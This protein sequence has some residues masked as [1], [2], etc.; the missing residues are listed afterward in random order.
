MFDHNEKKINYKVINIITGKHFIFDDD[1]L[2]PDDTNN[3]IINKII[4]Y[5]YPDSIISINEIYAYSGD[6]SICFEYDNIGIMNNIINNNKLSD[7]IIDSDF[8]NELGLQKVVK[9]NNNMN[10]LFEQNH[11]VDNTVYYFSLR[12]LF[13][14]K[15]IDLMKN[16]DILEFNSKIDMDFK[17]FFNGLIRKYF[18]KISENNIKNYPKYNKSCEKDYIRIKNL[19]QNNY[20]IFKLI[21]SKINDKKNLLDE[22]KKTFKLMK[23][24]TK[25]NSDNT[26]NITKLFSDFP[27][28]NKYFLSKLILEDYEDT[29]FKLY[30]KSLK[31][32][33]SSDDKLVTK[34]LCKLFLKDYKEYIP[35]NIGFVPSFVKYENI[36]FLKIHTEIK[37]GNIFFSFILHLDGNVDLIINNYN[38]ITIDEED[39]KQIVDE[40]NIII[41]RINNNRIYSLKTIP[42]LI[43]NDNLTLEYFN[44]DLIYDLENFIDDKGRYIYKKTNIMK[45]INNFY[46]HFRLLKE[47]MDLEDNNSIHVHYKRVSE[48]ENMDVFDSIISTMKHP[49]FDYSNDQIIDIIHENYGISMEAARSVFISWDEKNTLKEEQGKKIYR[50]ASKE[51]GSQIIIDKHL[52][53]SLKIQIMNISSFQELNR[54]IKFIRFMFNQYQNHISGNLD[55][56][57]NDLF[58]DVNKVTEKI[59]K[60][61]NKIVEPSKIKPKEIVEDS[62]SSEEE[63]VEYSDEEIVEE[64]EVEVVKKSKQNDKSSSGDE[65][66]TEESSGSEITTEESSGGGSSE[67]EII[68]ISNY[69]TKKLES[70]DS[71]LFKGRA[72]LCQANANKQAVALS[73]DEL[74]RIDKNDILNFLNVS[75]AEK[76]KLTKLSLPELI[77]QT[78][79]PKSVVQS[80]S[81][82]ISQPKLNDPSIKVNYICPKYWNI[83]SDLPIHP[84]DIHKYVDDI[85]PHGEKKGKTDKYVFSRT[86]SQWNHLQDDIF[87]KEI[88]DLLIKNEIEVDKKILTDNWNNIHKYINSLNLNKKILDSIDKI[89]QNIV[90]LIEPRWMASKNNIG[91]SKYPCCYKG[92]PKKPPKVE[93]IVI[94]NTSIQDIKISKLSPC[95]PGR[96]CHVHPKLQKLFNHTDD[97]TDSNLGGFIIRGVLQDNY[98]LIHSL[99]FLD[100]NYSIKTLPKNV[101]LNRIKFAYTKLGYTKQKIEQELSNKNNDFLKQYLINNPFDYIHNILVKY[102]EQNPYYIITKI[103][104]GNIVQLF[105]SDKFIEKDIKYFIITIRRD[106]IHEKFK[107]LCLDKDIIDINTYFKDFKYSKNIVEDF[108][109]KTLIYK[110]SHIIIIIYNIIISHNN[111]IDYLYSLEKKDYKYILPLINEMYPKNIFIFENKNESI[112]LKLQ[113]FKYESKNNCNFIYK[114]GDIY[115]PIVYFNKNL[116]TP[117]SSINDSS[118]KD[119]NVNKYI[120]LIIDGINEQIEQLYDQNQSQLNILN[121][122]DI[123][124]NDI[125]DHHKKFSFL[126]DSYCKISHIIDNTTSNIYPISPTSIKGDHFLIYNFPTKLPELKNISYINY[127]KKGIIVNKDNFI[128]EVIFNNNTYIPI[129]P[130]KYDRRNRYPI[131]GQISINNINNYLQT[132]IPCSDISNKFNNDYNYMKYFTRLVIQ[133]IIYYIKNDKIN[134]DYYTYDNGIYEKNNI[135]NFKILSHN[136]NGSL[137][138]FVVKNNDFF[139]INESNNFTGKVKNISNGDIKNTYKLSIEINKENIINIIVNN[140]IILNYDKQ[141]ELSKI[142]N[143]IIDTNDIFQIKNDQEYI[144]YVDKLLKDINIYTDKTFSDK[145][146]YDNKSNKLIINS[147]YNKYLSVIKEKVIWNLV[148]LLIINKNID[149][150]NNILQNNID[151]GDLSKSEKEGEIFFTYTEFIRKDKYTREYIKLNEIFKFKSS[152]IR[153]INF[154]DFNNDVPFNVDKYEPLEPELIIIPNIIKK[155]FGNETTIITYLDKFNMNFI[156]IER[157]LKSC[158]ENL[159]EDYNTIKYL[160][161]NQDNLKIGM[162]VSFTYNK[163]EYNG[164]IDSFK[165]NKAVIFVPKFKKKLD[166]SFSKLMYNDNFTISIED[167]QK[168][169]QHELFIKYNI[170]F[171]LITNSEDN[172]NLRQNIQLIYNNPNINTKFILLYHLYNKKYDSYNLTNIMINNTTNFLTLEELYNN[173]KI[174]Q[175]IITDYPDIKFS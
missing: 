155:L 131:I 4:N 141:V 163:K 60:I 144:L 153:E 7:L 99:I 170:G 46:T 20:D 67:S 40:S 3:M 123:V 76:K 24:S 120:K 87:K 114:N 23:L 66:S 105:K 116:S 69:F 173:D 117:N 57:Y 107:D 8:V 19:V 80:Y 96:F 92:N 55:K 89:Y 127:S 25:F 28:T 122:D 160:I 93:N 91:D 118:N 166:I 109:N 90:N 31:L 59:S 124:D 149:S 17:I 42:E 58:L 22:D 139:N 85:I 9:L 108:I 142:L 14:T 111:Y 154:Y 1:Q 143:D 5:C 110:N 98:S 62:E 11:I 77:K 119:L 26:I 32:E 33:L 86:G 10:K 97:I 125:A 100:S 34:N 147:K 138:N 72:R 106:D 2:Y 158:N 162:D 130:I 68:N 115:E 88:Y 47:R 36:F 128:I 150:V 75:S 37:S 73:D 159:S 29:Y 148:E 171:L 35:L 134:N 13:Q 81:H 164:V 45:F 112:N 152:F 49:R 95:N 21:D 48:Y 53:K 44:I 121:Y 140:N 61:E 175:I 64:P 63:V 172:T 137:K 6:K 84:R 145:C 16:P 50:F 161:Y 65:I 70:H 38:N 169:T 30:K 135:Y 79:V 18:P 103:G 27:L 104:D 156:A 129:K 43:L 165:N 136:I 15:D 113:L 167:L 56:K 74:E 71:D 151:R 83:R 102:L 78:K 41:K 54:I 157:G 146:I 132:N 174:R 82:I 126:V 12:E 39:L 168:I 133:S 101:L 52:E 51:P 94:K